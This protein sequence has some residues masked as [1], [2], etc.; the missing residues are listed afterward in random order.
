MNKEL[1]DYINI[2][3]SKKRKISAHEEQLKNIKKEIDKKIADLENQIAAFNKQYE[4][5]A[6]PIND[7]IDNEIKDL[8]KFLLNNVIQINLVDIIDAL[9]TITKENPEDIKVYGFHTPIIY[10]IIKKFHNRQD[11][12]TQI[13]QAVKEPVTVSLYIEGIYHAKPYYIPIVYETNVSEPWTDGKT[14]LDH[15]EIKAQSIISITEKGKKIMSTV[16][17]DKAIYAICAFN[18]KQIIDFTQ[19]SDLLS[20]AVMK[21]LNRPKVKVKQKI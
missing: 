2:Y 12:L 17:L 7:K 4:E 15:S 9:A 19:N 8:N 10:P 18:L 13:Y 11:L 14:L 20:Q 5:I 1:I 6:L 3:E 16:I 21:C